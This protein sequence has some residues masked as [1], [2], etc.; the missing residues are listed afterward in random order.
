MLS[1]VDQREALVP[2]LIGGP[3]TDGA[4]VLELQRE[5]AAVLERLPA[6]RRASRR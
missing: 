1:P 2:P 3:V 4:E 6:V 5:T